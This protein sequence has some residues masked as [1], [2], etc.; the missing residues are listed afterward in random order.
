[1]RTDPIDDARLTQYLLGELPEEDRLK[2]EQECLED[3]RIFEQLEAVEAE[4]TDDYVRGVLQG[5]RRQKFEK[6]LL[7]SSGG[8]ADIEFSR[9]ITGWSGRQPA[10][11]SFLTGL[12]ARISDFASPM[13]LF[14][15]AAGVAAAVMLVI[16]VGWLSWNRWFPNSPPPEVVRVR[17]SAPPAQP[18]I[19]PAP[20]PADG[21]DSPT[22]VATF[23][24][25]PGGVRS[26]DEAS[27]I[28]IPSNANKVRF[29][30]DL[31][32]KGYTNYEASLKR[33]EGGQ[34]F[35][36]RNIEPRAETT[37]ATVFVELPRRAIP[38]G[39]SV[40]TLTGISKAG[41]AEVVGKYPIRVLRR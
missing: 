32:A 25:T 1:V 23:I 14:R 6:R 37:G 29:R 13:W 35:S 38:F 34:L 27:E 19:A 5:P 11:R 4:L 15:A 8:A 36:L 3:D 41:T 22:F 16:A 39:T 31:A 28:N 10:R 2:L 40:L 21:S 18:Q 33:V 9:R 20:R 24:L 17:P 26:V 30:I 7:R 12:K